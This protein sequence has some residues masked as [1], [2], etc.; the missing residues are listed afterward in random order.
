MYLLP[1]LL[2]RIQLFALMNLVF[3]VPD[4]GYGAFLPL[5]WIVSG[6]RCFFVPWI[7]I[8]DGK[9]SRSGFGKNI[10][11]HIS[12]S[13][14]TILVKNYLNFFLQIRDL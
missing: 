4:P 5:A 13:L 6:I 14:E 12:D 9:K 1:G 8:R 10:P 3:S 11:D 2:I 7:R